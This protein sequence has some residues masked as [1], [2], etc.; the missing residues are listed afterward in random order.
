MRRLALCASVLFSLVNAQGAE[1]SPAVFLRKISLR[2][3]GR[4][5][6]L[7]EYRT[8]ESELSR[9]SCRQVSCAEKELRKHVQRLMSEPEFYAQAYARVTERFGYRS[10]PS[11]R[12]SKIVEEAQKANSTNTLRDFLLI[13]RVFKENRSLSELYQS[14]TVTDLA[15]AEFEPKGFA[16][17]FWLEQGSTRIDSE[18]GTPLTLENGR[19]FETVNWTL[20][21]HPNLAGLFSSSRFLEHHWNTPENQNRKRSAGVLR[22]MLCESLAPTLER[23]SQKARELRISLGISEVEV[24]KTDLKK[25]HVDLHANRKDCAQCHDRIDPIGNT[26]VPLEVGVSA[27]PFAGGLVDLDSYGVKQQTRVPNFASLIAT[28]IDRPGYLDCQARW[29]ID[30][31]LGKDIDFAPD[32]LAQIEANMAKKSLRTKE[33]IEDLLF[34]PEFFGKEVPQAKLAPEFVRSKEILSNCNECHQDTFRAAP[35][36]IRQ[37]LSRIAS[38]LD[39]NGSGKAAKMPP[40][41]HWW[42]PSPDE[43]QSIK[44]WVLSGA[45]ISSE[46]QIFRKSE[47]EKVLKAAKEN[48]CRE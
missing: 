41:D 47:I 29:L 5:P 32:R 38:C 44:S 15:G 30:T 24:L 35:E 22:V 12:L 25:A 21:G 11:S 1:L 34:L 4:Q 17:K 8:L 9:S 27:V 43:V 13:Y 39:L 16:Q 14:Q 3:V 48:P 2:L 26:L 20:K 33:I 10:P 46:F 42:G 6:T 7:Q 28:I 19:V 45:P 36:R 31:Y 40:S 37:R 18:S 23:E